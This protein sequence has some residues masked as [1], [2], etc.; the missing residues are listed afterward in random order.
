MGR[1][2]V[3]NDVKT[4]C[5]RELTVSRLIIELMSVSHHL[6]SRHCSRLLM[7]GRCRLV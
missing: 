5:S 4:G 2:T 7:N 1:P 6:E 3:H